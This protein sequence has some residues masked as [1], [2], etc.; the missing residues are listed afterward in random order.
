MKCDCC[1]ELKSKKNMS[2][3]S[4]SCR[5]SQ[6]TVS[7]RVVG[8]SVAGEKVVVQKGESVSVSQEAPGLQVVPAPPYCP[9]GISMVLSSV[10]GE[11]V[12]A[13]LD[14]HHMYT[15][16]QL[17]NYL[18]K[19][20][21][22]IP[23]TTREP[24]VIAATLAARQAALL[25][26]V[27][28]KNVSSRDARKREFAAEAASTLSFWALG[29]RPEHRSGSAYAEAPSQEGVAEVTENTREERPDMSSWPVP[30]VEDDEEFNRM[31]EECT[32]ESHR[33][34]LLALSPISS[35]PGLAGAMVV[36]TSGEAAPVRA[37]AVLG[38]DG[39]ASHSVSSAVKVSAPMAQVGPAVMSSAG[40]S[41]V[42]G[43][44]D[45]VPLEIYPP[46]DSGLDA[47]LS[48]SASGKTAKVQSATGILVPSGAGHTR[49]SVPRSIVQPG[50]PREITGPSGVRHQ[51]PSPPR[52]R[53]PRWGHGRSSSRGYR[54]AEDRVTLSIE[55]Y[56]DLV[57]NRRN[58]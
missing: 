12:L 49:P 42:S 43:T 33:T 32:E 51:R 40:V 34:S 14:Q 19:Y 54:R 37:G 46:S 53:S 8:P 4:R 26:G 2:R 20:Y 7:Q 31:I 15:L 57:R 29:L 5:G 35:T 21:P 28:E 39:L 1:G 24:I 58:K 18:E 9:T 23:A 30:V 36:A 41:L 11:A 45:D 17:T 3:H 47:D 22:E 10:L 27:V 52:D 44:S 16:A 56:H 13:L 48:S 55:E 6:V 25:H 50:R 38:P